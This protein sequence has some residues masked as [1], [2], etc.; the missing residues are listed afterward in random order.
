MHFSAF[1]EAAE[2]GAADADSIDSSR[3]LSYPKKHRR[4]MEDVGLKIAENQIS[5]ERWPG[6]FRAWKLLS[7]PCADEAC[8]KRRVARMQ[9]CSFVEN[10]PGLRG[11]FTR[12]MGD[13]AAS[14]IAWLEAH[15]YAR[16]AAVI[17]RESP[18]FAIKKRRGSNFS[19]FIRLRFRLYALIQRDGGGF[20]PN[21]TLWK[22]LRTL[23]P[24]QQKCDG[25]GFAPSAPRETQALCRHRIPMARPPLCP[26]FPNTTMCE[27][28]IPKGSRRQSNACALCKTSAPGE[29]GDEGMPLKQ[30]DFQTNCGG[31]RPCRERPPSLPTAYARM[32]K[33]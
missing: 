26:L 15:G 1:C 19:I 6:I 30:T 9:R 8:R 33:V 24:P 21:L 13:E 14:L 29:T 31:S 12:L 32:T 5:S 27:S 20:S 3:G 7:Y 16:E 17:G 23:S 11:T 28:L 4:A 10:A 2:A 18:P 22:R 25:C